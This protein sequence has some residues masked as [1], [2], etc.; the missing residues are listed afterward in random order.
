MGSVWM[1]KLEKWKYSLSIVKSRNFITFSPF[2]HVF[3]LLYFLFLRLTISLFPDRLFLREFCIEILGSAFNNLV[4]Q[5]RRV[6]ERSTT[7][8]D[9]SYLLWAMRFFLEFNRLSEFQLQL[10]R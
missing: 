8:N 7:G 2:L 3:L 9:D 10:V 5:V 1:E 6:L 4:R